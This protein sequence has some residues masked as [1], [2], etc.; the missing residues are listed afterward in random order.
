MWKPDYTGYDSAESFDVGAQFIYPS[1]SKRQ[2]GVLRRGP[3][4][5]MIRFALDGMPPRATAAAE[6]LENGGYIRKKD[7]ASGDPCRRLIDE[8]GNLVPGILSLHK[9]MD[10]L[11]YEDYNIPEAATISQLANV[12]GEAHTMKAVTN[13]YSTP[14][15]KKLL[16]LAIKRGW[17]PVENV[18]L[19]R[20]IDDTE[21]TTSKRKKV[22]VVE[23]EVAAAGSE[24]K[25]R[26]DP[27]RG[28]R[29]PRGAGR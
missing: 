19:G 23:E 20:R 7:L 9:V 17:G 13:T 1:N 24:P 25:K 18:T 11:G 2:L 10:A 16:A 28:P 27:R 12:L 15:Y 22:A 3:V 6:R 21:L 8:D 14:E 4:R 26:R 5:E 29:S